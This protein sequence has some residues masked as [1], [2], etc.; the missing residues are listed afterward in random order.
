MELEVEGTMLKDFVAAEVVL[1]LDS[2]SRSFS[3]EATS[4]TPGELPFKQDQSVR[5]FVDGDLVATGTIEVLNV[6][7][8]AAEH[9][10][11]IQ[12]R[13]KT[14]AIG[15]STL[16]NIPDI[17]AT[18][19]LKS[20]C[21]NVL[22]HLGFPTDENDPEHIAVIDNLQLEPFNSA[23]DQISPDLAQN[24]FDYMEIWARKRQVLLSS[25]A[26][27][28]LLFR[29]PSAGTAVFPKDVFLQHLLN[30]NSNNVMTYSTSYDS[31]GRFN[32]YIVT[33]QGNPTLFAISG[34]R[35][36]ADLVDQT[37]RAV[38]DANV[39]VGRQLVLT[40]ETNGSP[41]QNTARAE[42]ESNIRKF[43]GQTYQCTVSG[44]RNQKGNLWQP[45]D[46]V[47]V[48]DSYAN[49]KAQMRINNVIFSVGL[50]SGA[51]TQMTLL[52]PTVYTLSLETPKENEVGEALTEEGDE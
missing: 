7:G 23:E 5:A 13:D 49:I 4:E 43:K 35:D 28:N 30:N 9:S 44:F 42:W 17:T 2:L 11:S 46:L 36:V 10:I 45:G 38:L 8:S 1:S 24:A 26:D 22:K 31:T 12:G 14:G 37:G 39:R 52:E 51:T 27:G 47:F 48:N 21:E 32:R 18:V 29:Q 20:I 40:A 41:E 50:D 3:F 19:T 34:L 25:D 16:G 6:S 33:A 15:D